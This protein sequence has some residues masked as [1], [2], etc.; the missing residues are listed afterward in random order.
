MNCLRD[1]CPQYCDRTDDALCARCSE[2]WQEHQKKRMKWYRD[3]LK[4]VSSPSALP[5]FHW[6]RSKGLVWHN[7]NLWPLH[8][9]MERVNKQG[10]VIKVSHTGR[11]PT[12]KE[13]SKALD[14]P[15]CLTEHAT[16]TPSIGDGNIRLVNHSPHGYYWML[17]PGSNI[18][19]GDP[20]KVFVREEKETEKE[21][22]KEKEKKKEKDKEEERTTLDPNVSP[23]ISS[24]HRVRIGNAPDK[25]IP[26]NTLVLLKPPSAHWDS[27]LQDLHHS[28]VWKFLYD[29]RPSTKNVKTLMTK[30]KDV[31]QKEMKQREFLVPQKQRLLDKVKRWIE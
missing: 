15:F 20:I 21:T 3:A 4:H 26:L 16:I 1:Q 6:T 31:I 17:S 11:D 22:E 7:N 19:P 14:E 5:G 23:E 13:L 29:F 9:L 2:L 25:V 8:S 24:Y 28:D 12:G 18:F 10:L 27:I 30:W